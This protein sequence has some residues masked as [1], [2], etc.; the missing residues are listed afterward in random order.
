MSLSFVMFGFRPLRCCVLALSLSLSLYSHHLSTNCSLHH[1]PT[2][3]T[4]SG[5]QN[6]AHLRRKMKVYSDLR[7][8]CC[9]PSF[10]LH[11]FRANRA[12]VSCREATPK[13]CTHTL[14]SLSLSLSLCA[15]HPWL[16]S[17]ILVTMVAIPPVAICVRQLFPLFPFPCSHCD[18]KQP[19]YVIWLRSSLRRVVAWPTTHSPQPMSHTHHTRPT[20]HRSA[21]QSPNSSSN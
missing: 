12:W 1:R 2:N 6:C 4:W 5:Q 10:H 18:G 16:S 21:P 8:C 15:V 19:P 14:D 7:I 11:L 9:S 17:E 20:C 3:G 13:R